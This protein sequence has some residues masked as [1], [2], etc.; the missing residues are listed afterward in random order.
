MCLLEGLYVPLWF[1]NIFIINGHKFGNPDFQFAN[2]ADFLNP[3]EVPILENKAF[4]LT[5][6]KW[7]LKAIKR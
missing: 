2:E 1:E 6:A 5:A 7:S 3:L 4:H